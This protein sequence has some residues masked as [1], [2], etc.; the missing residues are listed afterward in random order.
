[1]CSSVSVAGASNVSRYKIFNDFKD[2]S[3][4]DLALD[5]SQK[6]CRWVVVR[7]LPVAFRECAF[8]ELYRDPVLCGWDMHSVVEDIT[9]PTCSS[10]LAW[11]HSC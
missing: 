5:S 10:Q 11:L 6:L 4:P 2:F 9:V 1:M 3:Y 8:V 7:P